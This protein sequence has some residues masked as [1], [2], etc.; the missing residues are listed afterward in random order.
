MHTSQNKDFIVFIGKW[1]K[2]VHGKLIEE[3]QNHTKYRMIVKSKVGL[4]FYI[5]DHLGYNV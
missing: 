5:F 4:T 1:I 2:L 3:N